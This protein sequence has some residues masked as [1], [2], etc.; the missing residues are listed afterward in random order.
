MRTNLATIAA[1][2]I[3]GYLLAG[4]VRKRR[5]QS[6]S[7][8]LDQAIDGADSALDQTVDGARTALRRPGG[9]GLAAVAVLAVGGMYLSK[10]L[11]T[12]PAGARTVEESVEVAVPLRTAY[13]QWTQFEDFPKFMATVEEVKQLDDTHLHWRAQVAGKP[14]EWDAEITEQT[15]DRRIAWRSTSGVTNAGVVTFHRVGDNRTRVM[16]QMD[17]EPE[18]MMERLGDAVGGVKLTAKGNLKRFKDLVEQRGVE[19]GAWRGTVPAH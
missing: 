11:R 14:K 16:L 13:D 5:Q 18:T 17:Y 12:G 19:S 4:Q 8:D 1:V 7:Y 3:G 10:S 15:P 9:K 6:A 2:T